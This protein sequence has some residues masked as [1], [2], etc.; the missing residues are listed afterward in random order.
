MS[1]WFYAV[2]N[3]GE[4]KVMGN[5]TSCELAREAIARLRKPGGRASLRFEYAGRDDVEFDVDQPTLRTAL[6]LRAF[7][8]PH[9][10]ASNIAANLDVS[11]KRV[12]TALDPLVKCGLIE[13]S[14]RDESLETWHLR[15]PVT[16]LE[17]LERRAE[18]LGLDLS[19]AL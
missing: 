13:I 15:A 14:H 16:S 5:N 1:F 8:P 12:H 4:N 9:F 6:Q 17:D 7:R 11:V 2:T 3:P 18:R 19:I 10:T